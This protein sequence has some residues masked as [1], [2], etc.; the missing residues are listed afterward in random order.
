MQGEVF[1][2]KKEIVVLREDQ[3]VNDVKHFR[4]VMQEFVR[5]EG[6]P[7][8]KL[9]NNKTRFVAVCKDNGCGWRIHAF[10]YGDGIAFKIKRLSGSHTCIKS[11]KGCG[12]GSD[13]VYSSSTKEFYVKTYSRKINP[14]P[15]ESKWPVVDH[16]VVHPNEE[17]EKKRGRKLTKR[18]RESDEKPAK[19]RSIHCTCSICHQIG[20]NS[21]S[22]RKKTSSTNAGE[23]H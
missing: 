17:M 19:K 23:L 18:R 7:I 11:M 8:E 16:P 5:Q 3:V 22:C 21:R 12:R 14:V 13:Q 1:K 4:E 2:L 9:K 6:F 15:D 20:H 10:L